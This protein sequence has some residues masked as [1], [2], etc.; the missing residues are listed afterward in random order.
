MTHPLPDLAQRRPWSPQQIR[1]ARQIELAPRLL[2]RGLAL[3]DRGG[4]NFEID[5]LKGLIIKSSYW[6]WPERDIDGN[7][8]DFYMKILGLSFADTMRE[9]SRS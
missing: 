1:A 3:R 4:G 5:S 9:L 7:T 6:R 2:K 8:I